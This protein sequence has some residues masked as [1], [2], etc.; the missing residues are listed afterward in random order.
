MMQYVVS[1]R[2]LLAK[3]AQERSENLPAPEHITLLVKIS[4]K[5]KDLFGLF[6]ERSGLG[7]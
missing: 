4:T 5:T 7:Y 1:F 6:F 2:D 3:V